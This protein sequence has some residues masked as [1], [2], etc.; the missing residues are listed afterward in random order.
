MSSSDE[1]TNLF[2]QL[3]VAQLRPPAVF[4]TTEHQESVARMPCH[5][6]AQENPKWLVLLC[7]LAQDPS[8]PACHH[9]S[10]RLL[11]AVE[12]LTQQID[13]ILPQPGMC[14]FSKQL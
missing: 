13:H 7:P 14:H 3:L 9:S 1:D 11:T 6:Q 5:M 12:W 8:A 4:K 2:S 10:S